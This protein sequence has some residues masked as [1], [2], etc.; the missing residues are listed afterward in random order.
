MPLLKSGKIIDDPWVCW[1]DDP[2]S[3]PSVGAVIVSLKQ[4]RDSRDRLLA[5]ATPLG[6]VLTSEQTPGEIE[7]D[8]KYFDLV[9]LDFPVFTDGRAYSNAKRLRQ[10]YGYTGEVRAVGQVQRDQYL[11]LHRCGF[12]ALVIRQGETEEDW[13]AA[14]RA[15]STPFQPGLDQNPTAMSLRQQRMMAEE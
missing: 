4:W 2:D 6:I 7:A 5:R 15:I 13:K 14:T 1:D 8:L 9:A 12:D 11:A 3:D 10:R